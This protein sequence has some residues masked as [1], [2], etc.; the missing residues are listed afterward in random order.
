MQQQIKQKASRQAK[1]ITKKEH[2]RGKKKEKKKKRK[3]SSHKGKP[4]CYR[5]KMA[6]SI[7]SIKEAKHFI[8]QKGRVSCYKALIKAN[9]KKPNLQS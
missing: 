3:K 2:K 1:E 6:G 8:T 9:M 5:S 7:A 4:A